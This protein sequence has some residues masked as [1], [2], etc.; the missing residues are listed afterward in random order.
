MV[1]MHIEFYTCYV[2][3]AVY[4]LLFPLQIGCNMLFTQRA[5]YHDH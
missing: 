1:T 3:S 2:I 4:F 5:A